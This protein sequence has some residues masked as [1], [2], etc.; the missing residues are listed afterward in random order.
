MPAVARLAR[1]D[2][3]HTLA[4]GMPAHGQT[5]GNA[6]DVFASGPEQFPRLRLL[7]AGG[8]VS[9]PAGVPDRALMHNFAVR[10]PWEEIVRRARLTIGIISR[11][12]DQT[13]IGRAVERTAGGQDRCVRFEN[14]R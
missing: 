11:R 3:Q 13:A 7:I 9:N 5:G 14:A 6:A 8:L 10:R 2:E 1:I 4:I 12:E